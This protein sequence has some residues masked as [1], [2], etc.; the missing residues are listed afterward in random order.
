MKRALSG[1][2]EGSIEIRST[3]AR[4]FMDASLDAYRL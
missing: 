3:S 4:T 2:A 1:D